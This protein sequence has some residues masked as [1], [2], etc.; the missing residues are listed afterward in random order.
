MKVI[1]LAAGQGTRL[2]PYTDDRPK[3]MV[4]LAGRPLL[5]HQLDVLRQA[6]LDDITV[7]GGYQSDQLNIPDVSLVLNPRYEQT[8]MV[9]TLFCAAEHMQSGDDLL[10][11]YG[12]IVFERQVLDSV[13]DCAGDVVVA[14]D[15][16]WQRLWRLRMDD[17]LSDAETFK[18]TDKNRV[19]ELGKKPKSY[20]DI[21][22]QYMGLIRIRKDKVHAFIAAYE[23]LD[24]SQCYDGMDI[25][26][27]YMTSFLQNLIDSGWDVRAAMVNGGW[28]EIDSADELEAYNILYKSG[29]LDE[30]IVLG[31][32]Q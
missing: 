4:E 28:L 7:V 15:R 2:R 21:E 9:Y 22:A 14:A 27:M 1:I 12:D 25:G 26:N 24:Q 3:C 20:N 8:N 19:T 32:T 23:S 17:P 13:L 5:H 16:D 18:V 11:S 31:G 10:I 30:F 6:K 29:G